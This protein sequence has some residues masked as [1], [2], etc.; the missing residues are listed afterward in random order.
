MSLPMEVQHPFDS[1]V[2]AAS[3]PEA[4][5]VVVEDPLEERTQDEPKHLLSNAI[6]DRGDA[7]GSRFAVALGDVHASQGEGPIGPALEVAHQGQQVLQKVILVELNADLVDPRRAAITFHVA[8][9]FEQ[10][11]LGNPSRPRVC[12]DL[13]HRQ[14]LSC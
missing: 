13:G 5:G 9:G 8:E 12:L 7:Q 1:H 14:V 2:T 10:E 11:R 3:R 4:I 6:A